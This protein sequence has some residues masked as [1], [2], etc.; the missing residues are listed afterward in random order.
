MSK[1]LVVYATVEGHT[2][3]VAETTG[4]WLSRAGHSV[5]VRDAAGADPLPPVESFDGAILC[6]SV[7]QGKHPAALGAFALE[8]LEALSRVPTALLSVSL[9]AAHHDAHSQAEARRYIEA[10]RAETGWRPTASLP[11]AGALRYTRYD[12]FKRLMMRILA[13]SRGDDVDT[14]RDW[15]YTDWGSL[16]LFVDRFLLREFGDGATGLY[17][18]PAPLPA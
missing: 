6:G 4:D 17:P 11:V 2:R 12:F 5:V 16:N 8:H 3:K 14:T 10:F 7:H 9:S 13:E 15:E 18:A 1:L